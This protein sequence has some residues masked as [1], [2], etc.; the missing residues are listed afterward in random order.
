VY[1]GDNKTQAQ[2]LYNFTLTDLDVLMQEDVER[3]L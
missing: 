2:K 1:P 3:D